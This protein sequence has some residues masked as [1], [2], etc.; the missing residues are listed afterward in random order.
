M[1]RIQYLLFSMI[2]DTFSEV[3]QHS[4]ALLAGLSILIRFTAVDVRG[5]PTN[6]FFFVEWMGWEGVQQSP[7]GTTQSENDGVWGTWE[8]Q[9][10]LKKSQDAIE[11]F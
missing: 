9:R 7:R 2:F 5:P 8:P 4:A 10:H 3:N 6:R 11:L 1:R